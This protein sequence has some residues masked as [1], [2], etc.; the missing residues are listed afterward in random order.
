MPA[1]D[2]NYPVEFFANLF[3]LTNRRVQQLA[4]DGVIPKASRNRY[5]LLGTVQGYVRYLQARSFSREAEEVGDLQTERTRLA[6]ANA[7]KTE[8]EVLQMRRDLAS[9]TLIEWTLNKVAIQI[10]TILDA[11]PLNIKRRI[12]SLTNAHMDLLKREIVKAQNAAAAVTI[13][14]D[15]YDPSTRN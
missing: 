15:E 2:P 8:M 13:D 11:T 6:K 5:P 14:L 9:I 3:S 4:K 7:D 12:P 10:G 1:N